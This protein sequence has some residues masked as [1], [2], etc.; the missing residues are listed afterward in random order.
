VTSRWR[1]A[2]VGVFAALIVA[3]VYFRFTGLNQDLVWHDE[4]YTQI[5]ASGYGSTDWQARF[6]RGEVF[7]AGD[8]EHFL[9]SD[10]QRGAWDTVRALAR[11]E[12]QHPPLYYVVARAWRALFGDSIGALRALSAC[13]SLLTLGLFYALAMELFHR[14]SVAWVATALM[15]VSPF[16]V[17]YAREA[18]EY[19]LFSL[20]LVGSSVALLRALRFERETPAR[21]T[22]WAWTLYALLLALGL[23]TSLSMAGVALA[24][25]L[26]VLSQTRVHGRRVLL[27]GAGAACASGVA[28]AP[29]AWA[30]TQH[31][32]SFRASMAWSSTIHISRPELMAHFGM[33]LSRP[34]YDFFSEPDSSRALL[35]AACCASALG[36]VLFGVWRRAEAHARAMLCALLVVP[37]AMFLL[38]DLLLGGIRSLSA[39]YLTSGLLAL[40]L[41]VS[42]TLAAPG[43]LARTRLV[44]GTLVVA[45]GVGSVLVDRQRDATW[46]KAISRALP[47]VATALSGHG[48]ALVIASREQ[49]HPGNLLALSQRIDPE[50]TLLVAPFAP[51]ME[52][53]SSPRPIYLF[54]VNPLLRKHIEQRTGLRARRLVQDLYADLWVLEEAR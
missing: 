35:A 41:G 29:W 1:L 8:V 3:G 14:R 36:V 22:R 43:K 40:V 2:Y 7:H 18:R 5:F 4:V 23:Y 31:W 28:F 52:I 13:A 47:R 9:R 37:V 26:V 6:F 51:P 38:P 15:S 48:D 32:Q 11:D 49:H 20:L 33:S 42:F 10:P 21:P 54:T 34:F 12:P 17:L 39:R 16:F 45:L 19:A 44:V 30:L 25:G 53:P 24:H 46:N 27:H 50:T